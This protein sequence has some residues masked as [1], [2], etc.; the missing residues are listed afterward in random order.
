ML[1]SF[2]RAFVWLNQF[3]VGGLMLVMTVL[4]FANVVLRYLAG[5][6]LPWVEEITRYMMIWVT[7]LGAGLALRAG[8]HVAVEL[9]Q[10]M[11]PAPLTHVLRTGIAVVI[12]VFLAAVAWYGFSY[13][14]FAMRQTSP[15]LNIPLG[16]VY[17]GIPLGCVLAAAHLMLGLR[18]YIAR[19]FDI[20]EDVAET[21]PEMLVLA[22]QEGRKI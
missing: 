15:V 17:L 6:S 18:R 4:V 14:Q 8:V 2:D 13:A 5:F 1:R 16:I 11:I 19:D 12:L 3:L 20:P 21:S 9:L 22:S 7:Y 10:D